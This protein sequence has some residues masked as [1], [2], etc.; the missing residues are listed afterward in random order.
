MNRKDNDLQV[1]RGMM[2]TP[3]N[4]GFSKNQQLLGLLSDLALVLR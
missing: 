3:T 4:S 1:K 2:L